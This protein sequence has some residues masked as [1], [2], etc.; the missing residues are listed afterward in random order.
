M[1]KIKHLFAPDTQHSSVGFSEPLSSTSFQR[2]AAG[3]SF[4]SGNSAMKSASMAA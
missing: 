4:A 1:N 3:K 2:S